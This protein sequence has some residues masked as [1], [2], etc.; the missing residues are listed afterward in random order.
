[1]CL[2]NP[3]KDRVGLIDRLVEVFDLEV[4]GG[5]LNNNRV[6]PNLWIT[7]IYLISIPDGIRFRDNPKKQV[8]LFSW[9]GLYKL[10]RS[11]S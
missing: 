6:F 10:K 8:S 11:M 1:M 5:V 9:Y 3:K 2:S 7:V 4:F